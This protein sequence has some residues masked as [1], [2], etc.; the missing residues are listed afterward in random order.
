M[1]FIVISCL[2]L[3]FRDAIL[4]VSQ[5]FKSFGNLIVKVAEKTLCLS[6]LLLKWTQSV[7]EVIF[8]CYGD[9]RYLVVRWCFWRSYIAVTDAKI[10]SRRGLR[11]SFVFRLGYGVCLQHFSGVFSGRRSF[12]ERRRPFGSAEIPRMRLRCSCR[13]LDQSLGALYDLDSSWLALEELIDQHLVIALL[14]G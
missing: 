7:I 12:R 10:S 13:L 8:S 11:L 3:E 2:V 14:P 4:M 6:V 5:V 9:L 1:L